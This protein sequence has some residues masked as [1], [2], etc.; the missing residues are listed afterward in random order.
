[1]GGG[2]AAFAAV[3]PI[4]LLVKKAKQEYMQWE[5]LMSL[6]AAAFADISKRSKDFASG[7]GVTPPIVG[8]WSDSFNKTLVRAL[9]TCNRV[10]ADSCN[11]FPGLDPEW[12]SMSQ[13][14]APSHQQKQQKEPQEHKKK[15]KPKHQ[16]Q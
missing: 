5:I 16:Y 8:L 1:M 15:N 14:S 13:T 11:L 7:S 12:L 10:K 9:D 4:R 6:L 2:V 3:H